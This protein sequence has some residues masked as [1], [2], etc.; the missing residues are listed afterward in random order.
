MTKV[1]V[2]LVIPGLT[3][4]KKLFSSVGKPKPGEAEVDI[5]FDT[6]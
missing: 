1:I 6:M 2:K 3:V 5:K 4:E